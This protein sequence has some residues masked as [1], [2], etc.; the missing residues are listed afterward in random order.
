MYSIILIFII[1]IF[2]IGFSLIGTYKIVEGQRSRVTGTKTGIVNTGNSIVIKKID[3][4]NQSIDKRLKEQEN[5]LNNKMNY[6]QQLTLNN[7]CSMN[8][9]KDEPST[10][11]EENIQKFCKQKAKA[12]KWDR[13]YYGY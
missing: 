5:K 2:I 13:E 1:I 4:L 3:A 9:S 11:R 10:K 6:I 8:Y 12:Y 7:Y